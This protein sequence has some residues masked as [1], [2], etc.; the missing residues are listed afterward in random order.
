MAANDVHSLS[1]RMAMECLGWKPLEKP[2][3]RSQDGR[4]TGVWFLE[5]G[6]PGWCLKHR[7]KNRPS[8]VK[9]P[10]LVLLWITKVSFPTPGVLLYSLLGA[11]R[12]LQTE[13]W[14]QECLLPYT[15][16]WI[17]KE[18]IRHG[19]YLVGQDLQINSHL[20]PL[21]PS[22]ACE[23]WKHAFHLYWHTPVKNRYWRCRYG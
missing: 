6:S 1:D 2:W 14:L 13:L 16:L 8:R 11:Y 4:G 22:V 7:V 12:R 18:N 9:G 23:K 3:L 10:M 21:S 5:G 17:R 15:S 20:I 19:G